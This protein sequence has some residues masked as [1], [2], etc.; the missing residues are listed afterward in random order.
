MNLRFC[1]LPVH[2]F[3]FKL[4][5]NVVLLRS[6]DDS[7]CRAIS[8][9]RLEI[10][11]SCFWFVS[12]CYPHLL[13]TAWWSSHQKWTQ[14]CF[15]WYEV[16]ELVLSVFWLCAIS[17]GSHALSCTHLEWVVCLPLSSLCFC[18]NALCV[19]CAGDLV[20]AHSLLGS[21]VWVLSSSHSVTV[22]E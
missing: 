14:H 1:D 10:D 3:F 18:V 8:Q 16:K 2:V 6:W 20:F 9:H 4:F 11:H 22:I 19:P 17:S 13:C 21:C 5:F 15:Q 7:R 12:S